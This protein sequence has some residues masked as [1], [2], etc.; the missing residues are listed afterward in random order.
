MSAKSDLC[1]TCEIMKINIQY[2]MQYEKKLELTN[3]YL[4]YLNHA[5]EE[6]DYYNVNIV[7]ATEDAEMPDDR[8]QEKE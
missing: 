6:R 8:K 3:N 4:A 2:T 1:E 7:K 5:Q